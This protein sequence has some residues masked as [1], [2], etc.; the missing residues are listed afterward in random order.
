M[1]DGVIAVLL[2]G[3]SAWF[4][5]ERLLGSD[6]V[7][8]QAL[9]HCWVGGLLF[10]GLWLPLWQRVAA[11]LRHAARLIAE[12]RAEFAL[13]SP[14]WVE[15]R[16]HRIVAAV[17]RAEEARWMGAAVAWLAVALGLALTGVEVYAAWDK[18]T[19]ALAARFG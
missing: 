8:F 9:A 13:E 6:G 3:G 5:R 4:G 18:I 2:I 15:G 17:G 14:A 7:Q 10:A 19:A 16:M 1:R 11:E 12:L